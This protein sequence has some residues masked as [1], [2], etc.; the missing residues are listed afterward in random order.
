MFIAKRSPMLP[1]LLS[2]GLSWWDTG[3]RIIAT[4]AQRELTPSQIQWLNDL[5][6]LWPGESGTII[7]LASWQDDIKNAGYRISSMG[8]WHYVDIPYTPNASATVYLPL[9]TFNVTS[10]L[11]DTLDLLF[12]ETTTSAWALSFA[13]RNLVHFLGDAHCPM[14]G[15]ELFDS[16]YPN[17]D[18]GGNSFTMST[19]VFGTN[20]NNLHKYWDSGGFSYQ[21]PWPESDFE[22]NLTKILETYPR[23]ALS[24]RADNL[25]PAQWSA[26]A[27][28]VASGFAYNVTSGTT[29][30]QEYLVKC[31]ALSEEL[32]AVAGYRLANVLK[33]FFAQRGFVPIE[34]VSSL[35]GNQKISGGGITSW[36][37]VA[38]EILVLV[39][40]RVRAC[41]KD[42]LPSI[43]L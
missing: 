35:A 3:H 43:K 34:T 30:S 5:F 1:L 36:V 39:V 2:A 25:E 11:V 18:G 27:Y 8:T 37:F 33:K 23:S 20:G 21:T 29:A 26:E 15:V 32:F 22:A 38:A 40:A 14:H 10:V 17:G 16:R 19:A 12:D 31:R 41:R 7:T 4:I 6:S 42:P 13:M 28:G 24:A 9:V